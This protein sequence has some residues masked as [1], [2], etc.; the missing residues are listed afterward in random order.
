MDNDIQNPI[1]QVVQNNQLISGR[2]E[3][4]LIERRVFLKMISLIRPDDSDFK[5]FYLSVKELAEDI[6]TNAKSVYQ[7]L[8]RATENMI[9][10]VVKIREKDRFIQVGL[11]SSAT[12]YEKKGILQIR[13]DP[14]LKPYLLQ[15][16][17]NFTVYGLQY[18]LKFKSFYSLRIYEMLKQFQSTGHRFILLEDLRFSLGLE[19]GQYDKYGHLKSRILNHAQKELAKSDIPFSFKEVKS[20]KKVIAI[21]FR[22]E[23]STKEKE[24]SLL[25]EA[26]TTNRTRAAQTLLGLGL[27]ERQSKKIMS[28][29]SDQEIFK[30]AYD[31]N[32]Q[33]SNGKINNKTAYA[34]KVFMSKI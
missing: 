11:I 6:G 14:S 10:R 7:D 8:Q 24:A 28:K 16:K 27:N 34:Y 31:I 32:L 26:D 3:M 9:K 13:F 19:E 12:Y 29:I 20:G 1:V 17:N 2:Y 18:V 5:D 33:V 15:L 30:T 21:D 25:V 22:F 4:S 23:A